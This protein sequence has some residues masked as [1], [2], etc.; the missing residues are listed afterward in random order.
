MDDHDVFDLGHRSQNN[1]IADCR[2]GAATGV[3]HDNAFCAAIRI[4]S[5]YPAEEPSAWMTGK[6]WA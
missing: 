4:N 1:Y 3:T 5:F 2:L 6:K